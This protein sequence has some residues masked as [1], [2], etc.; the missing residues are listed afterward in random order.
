[1]DITYIRAANDVN[2]NPRRGWIIDTPRGLVFL[3]EGYGGHSVLYEWLG[4]ACP[5]QESGDYPE[6]TLGQFIFSEYVTETWKN[7]T[8]EAYECWNST[9]A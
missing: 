3:D 4:S 1:M 9:S 6:W 2:G 8:A 5:V 7:S